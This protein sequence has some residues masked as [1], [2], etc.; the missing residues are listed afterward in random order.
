MCRDCS[1]GYD[2]R[3]AA[4]GPAELAED[5][6]LDAWLRRRERDH[7]DAAR[8]RGDYVP[9]TT[10]KLIASSLSFSLP[11]YGRGVSVV[12]VR[13]RTYRL[14]S[15]HRL[16]VDQVRAALGDGYDV[17]VVDGTMWAR[18]TPGHALAGD[19]FAN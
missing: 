1:T 8:A 17:R 15:H 13:D 6:N 10:T 3:D 4:P 11:D 2:V 5:A 18:A 12:A 14:D 19:P 9:D 7:E 16:D